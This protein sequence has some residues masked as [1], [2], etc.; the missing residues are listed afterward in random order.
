MEQTFGANHVNSVSTVSKEARDGK[1][2]HSIPEKSKKFSFLGVSRLAVKIPQNI[3]VNTYWGCS[4]SSELRMRG[5]TPPFPQT[6]S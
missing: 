6:P 3:L 5:A 2:R 1:N 4:S